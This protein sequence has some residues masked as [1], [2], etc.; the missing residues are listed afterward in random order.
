MV[1]GA[2]AVV[3]TLS[4]SLTES[5]VMKLPSATTPIMPKKINA[6]APASAQRHLFISNLFPASWAGGGLEA[7]VGVTGG[8][9]GGA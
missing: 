9:V 1:E 7:A 3:E 6:P 5:E 8:C 2:S 4:V